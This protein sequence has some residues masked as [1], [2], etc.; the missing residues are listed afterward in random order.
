[1]KARLID[2]IMSVDTTGKIQT[3][4]MIGSM[5]PEMV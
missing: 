3:L 2:S 5:N 4:V 1:M